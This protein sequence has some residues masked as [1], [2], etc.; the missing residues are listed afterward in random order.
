[1][2]D[3]QEDQGGI[4]PSSG[5]SP[6]N[7]LRVSNGIQSSGEAERLAREADRHR[8]ADRIERREADA[9][10]GL[11]QA[12][13]EQFGFELILTPD[14]AGKVIYGYGKIILELRAVAGGVA[15]LGGGEATVPS[16][17]FRGYI[18]AV[19]GVPKIR[20]QN[21]DINSDVPP[22]VQGGSAPVDYDTDDY[23]YYVSAEFDTDGVYTGPV[24]VGRAAS[25]PSDTATVAYRRI[26]EVQDGEVLQ[27]VQNSLEVI[28]C[29]GVA[30]WGSV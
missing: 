8:E 12:F 11:A 5:I 4:R 25:V 24:T 29:A 2:N 18:E 23:V 6:S 30:S 10:A 19:S 22:E 20:I 17:P 9:L 21:G 16:F 26:F 13:K 27:S 3:T 1:M 15:S 7:G 14:D 28:M